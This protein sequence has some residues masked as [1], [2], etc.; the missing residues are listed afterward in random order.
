MNVALSTVLAALLAFGPLI[1]FHE[2]GHYWVAR[3]CG[4]KVLRFSIGLG[5]VVWSRR[6][7]PDQTEWAVSM[8]PLGGYVKMLDRSDP[9]AP[10][11]SEAD[12]RREFTNQTVWRRI[13]IIAAG[14]MA[15]YL[16]AILLFA[17]LYMHGIAEPGTRLRAMPA[18]T[19]A[20]VAGLR[21]GDQITAVNGQAVAL[22]SDLH[23]EIM[24]AAIAK[25]G[26]RLDVNRPD[27]GQASV[28]I[29]P[30][31]LAGLDLEGDVLEKLGIAM[32]RPKPVLLEVQEGGAAAR[33]GL[34][35]GDSVLAIDG[36]PLL[37]G[38][39]FID[40]IRASPGKPLELSLVR[41]GRELTLAVTPDSELDAKGNQIGRIKVRPA[42]TPEMVTSAAPPFTAL[43]KGAR[44][45]GDITVM[46]VKM[47]GKMIVGEVSL[48]NLSGPLTIADYAGQSARIGALSYLSFIA[49]FSASLGVM[50]LLPIPVLDGGLLLYYSLEVLTGRPLPER[51]G[52]IV[53]FAGFGLLAT[54]MALAVFN[55]VVRLL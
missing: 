18:A 44:K 17:G 41:A 15:N 32:A 25:E 50:N 28:T 1:I 11:M 3:A 27:S 7:G 13:A 37:D 36:K 33:A 38:I 42:L 43:A 51:V 30:A 21:G 2:L 20:Y 46:T 48:K 19:P 4:V 5:K 29:P 23:W 10:P 22:W 9:D 35:A 12:Q 53:R 55:D 39:D 45:T 47:V 52:E 26:V 8:L 49:F 34:R 24:Q 54:L 40:T 14:P 6:F 31:A 16:L